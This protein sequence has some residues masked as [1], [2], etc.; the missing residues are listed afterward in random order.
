MTTI[1]I[2]EKSKISQARLAEASHESQGLMPLALIPKAGLAE[3]GSGCSAP[4]A[5]RNQDKPQGS[6]LGRGG[7]YHIFASSPFKPLLKLR[8]HFTS[9]PKNRR[10]IINQDFFS[11]AHFYGSL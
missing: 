5:D 1:K 9:F 10:T 3:G 2:I 11:K 7:R 8:N 6:G 4:P